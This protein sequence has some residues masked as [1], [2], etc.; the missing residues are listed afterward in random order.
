MKKDMYIRR[1][2]ITKFDA[3]I[4]SWTNPNISLVLVGPGK[5]LP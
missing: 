3:I 4:I 5:M 1:C 2:S